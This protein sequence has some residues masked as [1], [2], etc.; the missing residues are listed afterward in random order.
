MNVY[1][2]KVLDTA[3]V[4]GH[5]LL[6][7]GAEISRVEETMERITKAYGV[8]SGNYFVLSSG[9]FTTAGSELGDGFANV[10]Y[11]PLSSAKLDKVVAVN[12]LSREI[13]EGAYTVEE[14]RIRLSE[15]QAMKG[16]PKWAQ[17]LA[18]ALG[19][20]CFCALFGGDIFD[21]ITAFL[22]GLILYIFVLNIGTVHLSKI[23]ANLS[24]GAI[25]SL[26]AILLYQLGLGH[27][28]EYVIIGS[29]IP[30]IP[31]MSFTNGIRDI[32]NGDYL[33]GLVRM[34]DALL[35]TFSAAMGVGL[36]LGIYNQITG[37][38]LL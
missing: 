20:G 25:V 19:S 29:I 36:V 12:Q 4:A 3:V 27:H 31:G 30:L 11:I 9:I 1:E 33:A 10:K 22:V 28:F 15:I 16:K 24:G 21:S 26:L 5:I 6:E 32:A 18:A 13:S 37:G 17:I 14:A 34:I 8:E 23:V 2:K 35:I 7:N 38:V